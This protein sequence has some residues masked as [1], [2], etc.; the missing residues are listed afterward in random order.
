[1]EDKKELKEKNLAYGGMALIE[2]VLMRG[3]ESYAIT[4]K[5]SDDNFYKE[6]FNYV[7]LGK[8][9]KF[10]G[11]PLI[12]GVVGFIENMVIGLKV[13]NKSAA[14]AF[15]EEE[16]TKSMSNF[17]MTVI[18]IISM[19]IALL[20]FKGIPYM[21]TGIFNLDHNNNPIT[22]NLLSGFISLLMFFIYIVSISFMKDTR[23]VF[24]YHGAEHKTIRA[25]EAKVELTVEN[26]KKFSKHHPRCGTAFLFIVF[27]ISLFI[28]PLFNIFFNTQAWYNHIKSFGFMGIIIQRSIHI[29]AHILIGMPII[30]AI[31]YE[32]LKL[33]AKF[34]NNP[35]VKILIAPG[36]FF[37][38]FT[39]KEPDSTMIKAA[40]LSLKMVLGEEDAE[41]PREVNDDFLSKISNPLTSTAVLMMLPVLFL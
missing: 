23:R 1:M 19:F 24:S 34:Q 20:I 36:L 37:Q 6:K 10:L 40:A 18:L 2:G 11:L 8:R 26:I 39:T 14:V 5:K 35:L 17:T 33:S 31:S 3:M 41:T 13:L 32:L 30:A 12:R 25:Y 29:V 38:L 16:G 27:F 22:Y 28:F 4:I 15:P 7:S 9:I 21:L